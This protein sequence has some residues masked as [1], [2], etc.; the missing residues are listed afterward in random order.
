MI[1]NPSYLNRFTRSLLTGLFVGIVTTLLCLVYNLAFRERTGFELSPIINVA[2][3]IF[4]INLL[5]PAI[6]I[7]FYSCI[8]FFKRGEGIY[9][10]V[11]LV[12]TILFVFL[13]TGVHRT[14]DPVQNTEFRH[15]LMA[16]VGIIGIM[17]TAALPYL[18]HSKSFEEHVL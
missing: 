1:M 7:L 12:L 11:M 5:F 18:F 3:L 16:V 10:I 17:A 15:L 13:S 8:H 9:T 2:S 14:D 4:F 6:G